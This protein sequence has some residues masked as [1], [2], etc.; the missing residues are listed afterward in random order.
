PPPWPLQGTNLTVAELTFR[1]HTTNGEDALA[2]INGTVQRLTTVDS[3]SNIYDLTSST[4]VA[5]HGAV[6]IAGVNGTSPGSGRRLVAIPPAAPLLAAIPRRRLRQTSSCEVLGD[7]NADCLFD[8]ADVLFLQQLLTQESPDLGALA[9]WQ[10]AQMD[11]TKDS[12]QAAFDVASCKGGPAYGTPCATLSDAQYLLYVLTNKYRFLQT[13]S[14]DM[15]TVGVTGDNLHMMLRLRDGKSAAAASQVVVRFEVFTTQNSETLTAAQGTD[16]QATGVGTF[17]LTAANSGD[18]VYEAEV[19]HRGC[20]VVGEELKVAAI[21]Q[22]F[23]ET[24]DGSSPERHF[25]FYGSA[26][27]PFGASGA[28]ATAI[29]PSATSPCLR[30]LLTP[31]HRSTFTSAPPPHPHPRRPAAA[32]I[33]PPLPPPFP[34]PPPPAPP[35]FLPPPVP[36]TPPA[37]SPE[38]FA[39]F[40]KDMLPAVYQSPG[41][42]GFPTTATMYEGN[43]SFVRHW[44]LFNTL[45][46][47][48]QGSYTVEFRVG[49][50]TC[51]PPTH[52]LKLEPYQSSSFAVQRAAVAGLAAVVQTPALYYDRGDLSAWYSVTDAIG[53]AQV[54]VTWLRMTMT[55]TVADNSINV[56]CDAPHAFTGVGQCHLAGAEL[57]PYFEEEVGTSVSISVEASYPFGAGEVARM[58]D[59]STV[60][61]ARYPDGGPVE[62]SAAGLVLN[63]PCSPRFRGDAIAVAV[64]AHTGGDALS[65]FAFIVTFDAAVLSL[66]RYTGDAAFL[67]PTVSE[68]PGELSVVSVG[69]AHGITDDVVTSDALPLG[70]ISFQVDAGAEAGIHRAA[71]S[72]VIKEMVTTATMTIEGTVNAVAQIDDA[73]GSSSQGRLEVEDVTPTGLLVTVDKAE[74]YNTKVLSSFDHTAPDLDDDGDGEELWWVSSAVTVLQVPGRAKDDPVP[75]STDC[76]LDAALAETTPTAS[77]CRVSV[78]AAGTAGGK[79]TVTASE[80]MRGATVTARASMRVWFPQSAIFEVA[81]SFLNRTDAMAATCG[82]SAYQG[83]VAHAMV[84]FGG[85]DLA[86]QPAVDMACI[87]A[88]TS[89]DATV[90]TT[91]FNTIAAV[92]PGTTMI[93]AEGASSAVPVTPVM[94]TVS[95]LPA[96]VERLGVALVTEFEWDSVPAGVSW[97]DAANEMRSAVALRQTLTQ[98]GAVGAVLLTV[99]WTDGQIT[100]LPSPEGVSVVVHGAAAQQSLELVP[101]A[102]LGTTG[103]M[104]EARVPTGASSGEAPDMLKAE[105]RDPCNAG[106]SLGAGDGYVKVQLAAPSYAAITAEHAAI[107]AD[108]DASA[109][110]PIRMPTSAMLRVTV[111]YEDG[112]SKDF[113]GDPRA[114]LTVTSGAH[115]GHL[116][117]GAVKVNATYDIMAAGSGEV[118]VE[119]SFPDYVEGAGL[120]AATTVAVLGLASIEVLTTPYP[121]YSGS[122]DKAHSR[123]GRVQCSAQYQRAS[124]TVVAVLT[125]SSRYDTSAYSSVSVSPQGVDLANSAN[126]KVHLAPVRAGTYT[127]TGAYQY[128]QGTTELARC[129]PPECGTGEANGKDRL[130]DACG[131]VEALLGS[132]GKSAWAWGWDSARWRGLIDFEVRG[133]REQIEVVDEAVMITEVTH[134][135]TWASESTFSAVAGASRQLAAR[136]VFEDGTVLEDVVSGEQAQWLPAYELV[137]FSSDTT[138]AVTVGQ[139]EDDT[140]T[141]KLLSN[142]HTPVQLTVEAVCATDPDAALPAPDTEE[143]H[144]N[145][146]PAEND[147]DLGQEAGLQFPPTKVGGSFAAEVAVQVGSADLRLFSLE[148]HFDATQLRPTACEPGAQWLPYTFTCTV[149]DPEVGLDTILI[150]GVE[151]GAT[152]VTGRAHVA[153]V[154]MEVLVEASSGPTEMSGAVLSLRTSAVRIAAAYD[155]VAGVGSVNVR[156]QRRHLQST[157]PRP[158]PRRRLLQTPGAGD[159]PGDINGDGKFDAFDI[160]AAMKWVA[161]AALHTDPS[162]LSTFQRQ[163]LDP[164]LDYLRAPEDV[165]A[166]PSGWTAGTPCPTSKDA[167]YLL[168]VYA[169][170]L[171]FVRISAEVGMEDLVT[172]PTAAGEMLKLAVTIQDRNGGAVTRANSTKAL[173]E[174][175]LH[176]AVFSVGSAVQA[177]SDGTAVTAEGPNI[178]GTFT[179]EC[180]GTGGAGFEAQTGVELAFI[181]RTFDQ[182]LTSDHKRQFAFAGSS[183]AG[184][185]FKAFSSF[186]LQSTQDTAE[187]PVPT[188]VPDGDETN[189]SSEA[190]DLSVGSILGIVIAALLFLAAT[191]LAAV[192]VLRRKKEETPDEVV[193]RPLP[194]SCRCSVFGSCTA[195]L[196]L[197]GHGLPG[198]KRV[199]SLYVTATWQTTGI[200]RSSIAYES[201]VCNP[202][203]TILQKRLETEG[204]DQQLSVEEMLAKMSPLELLSEVLQEAQG[205]ISALQKLADS[206]QDEGAYQSVMQ[207]LQEARAILKQMVEC[208]SLADEEFDLDNLLTLSAEVFKNIQEG[209]A[210]AQLHASD[211]V[212]NLQIKGTYDYSLQS[213]ED[214]ENPS[215]RRLPKSPV[216]ERQGSEF[217]DLVAMIKKIKA[218]MKTVDQSNKQKRTSSISENVSDE[219]RKKLLMRRMGADWASKARSESRAGGSPKLRTGSRAE[220]QALVDNPLFKK[221]ESDPETRTRG[222]SMGQTFSNMI[223]LLRRNTGGGQRKATMQSVDEEGEEEV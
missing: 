13:A 96:E 156:Q 178:N 78:S 143:V 139:S 194:C 81:D 47:G 221:K 193:M 45:P 66:V 110:D 146:A 11:P 111:Y 74:L 76:A 129:T 100:D 6:H 120:T 152:G 112:S 216:R 102:E 136:A 154:T 53:W 25:P 92:A 150:T 223:D 218:A 177:T 132:A 115:I 29:T 22:T 28:P 58:A 124:I 181:V 79:L 203:H 59:L 191:M 60:L 36:F 54:D 44:S 9:D 34:P 10:R 104:L 209:Q 69:L 61:A 12:Y 98:E 128:A 145:L 186:D 219:L 39:Q 200:V 99:V 117:N 27:E 153:T 215:P 49:H 16:W 89:L 174:L 65:T 71:L 155:M 195:P 122:E 18:G 131:A 188:P 190:E 135:T 106:V 72:C 157:Q 119:V 20:G 133:C 140:G 163:Q 123:L 67:T 220:S 171:R 103:H 56:N 80:S 201:M 97:D 90:A 38:D 198:V 149:N 3:D 168:Y 208:T 68:N 19:T 40:A 141:T 125:N 169:S 46:P 179:A 173:F 138:T 162:S 164:T 147:A 23:D 52:T 14:Q 142:H 21:V 211:D 160:E 101:E 180:N 175:T 42:P 94:V 114:V 107:T 50:M 118:G 86:D 105:W 64:T 166:C 127:V 202:L 48:T 199:L 130:C 170:F 55:V 212:T 95:D 121:A 57:L 184:S 159:K 8:V 183:L 148:V 206:L 30:H 205:D 17:M 151:L 217:A 137:A 108:Q 204:A 176:N 70:T 109:A 88:L 192:Y 75:K 62:L 37:I 26:T 5:G 32:S 144:A 187:E 134:A 172:V 31:P 207:A 196:S 2:V 51:V 222:P 189:E 33:S 87:M 85:A 77:G 1:T 214:P 185:A 15:L 93:S 63:L 113:T 83:T 161:A 116:S 91:A 24:G 165:S 82:D 197:V 182:G 4:I 84:V 126:S 43:S 167:Q 7:T 213:Q 210:V 73:Y 158:R 35:P 41:S